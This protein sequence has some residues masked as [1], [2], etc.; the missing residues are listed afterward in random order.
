MRAAA[1]EQLRRR[2]PRGGEGT[3]VTSP[4]RMVGPPA[5]VGP[6]AVTPSMTVRFSQDGIGRRAECESS[7]RRKKADRGVLY[8]RFI[9]KH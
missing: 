8:L 5:H 9:L 6:P 7:A 3:C 4:E 2:K 1:V